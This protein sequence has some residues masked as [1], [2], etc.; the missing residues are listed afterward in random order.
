MVGYG[1]EN[2]SDYAGMSLERLIA[3]N[4]K[5]DEAALT[6]GEVG[7]GWHFCHTGWDG[8]L[9]SPVDAEYK[10]CACPHTQSHKREASY[11]D[12]LISFGN[13]LKENPQYPL[14]GTPDEWYNTNL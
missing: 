3:L 2:V 14:D 13:F 12:R 9:I 7:A 11:Y 10:F 1:R 5:G 6:P 8:L 4:E